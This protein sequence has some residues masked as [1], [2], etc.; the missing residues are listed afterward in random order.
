[1]RKDDEKKFKVRDRYGFTCRLAVFIFDKLT[2]CPFLQGSAFVEF[3]VSDK[4]EEVCAQ[5][6]TF[7]N[8]NIL[9]IMP[10]YVNI[11]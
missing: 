2:R 3:E 9:E 4:V 8:N 10:K 7:D 1:M 11:I 6:L 5:R